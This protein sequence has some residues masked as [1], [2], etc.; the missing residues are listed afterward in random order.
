MNIFSGHAEIL[1]KTVYSTQI[2]LKVI[3]NN[4]KE[5]QN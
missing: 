3:L 4:E 1:T 2:D 5:R